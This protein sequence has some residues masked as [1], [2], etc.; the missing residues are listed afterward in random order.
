MNKEKEK[1]KKKGSFQF[2]STCFSSDCSISVRTNDFWFPS[3]TVL[4]YLNLPTHTDMI[5]LRLMLPFLYV[6]VLK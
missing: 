3:V 5:I 4:N 6:S 1:G 2:T